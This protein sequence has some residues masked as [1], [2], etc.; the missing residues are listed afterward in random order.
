MF[1]MYS[2]VEHSN[3]ETEIPPVANVVQMMA[4]ETVECLKFIQQYNQQSIAR[5]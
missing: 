3:V 2:F 5:E 1:R 4:Q